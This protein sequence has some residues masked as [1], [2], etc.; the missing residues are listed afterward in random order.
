MLG[1]ATLAGRAV[2]A[3]PPPALVL[4]GIVSVQLGAS[5]AK[6]MFAVAGSLGVVAMRLVFAAVVLLVVWRPS[7]RTLRTLRADRRLLTV[8][9]GYGA[10]LAGMNMAFYQALARIPQGVAVT[11]E[12]L[13]PLSVA[14][15]GSRRWLDALWAALAAAGV[16]L[17]TEDGGAVRWTG[18]AFALL[19]AACWA[20]YI[21]LGAALGRRTTDGQGLAVA[22]AFGGLFA[23]PLGVAQAG[24]T[25]LRPEVLAAGLAVALLSS[26]VPY[27]LELEAL[28]R[29]PPRVFGVLMSLEPAVAALAGLVVLGEALA[30]TQWLAIC[31]V[32]VASIGATRGAR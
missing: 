32:V 2:S 5:V 7:V 11:V 22:M 9:L 8:V 29:I 17:L 15:L 27:S 1:L 26:V 13:G 14:L 12:F 24:A 30:P 23:A 25:L 28:R 16:L 18:V 19:A 20:S 21:L 31:C 6:Q 3:T 4:L 10:V